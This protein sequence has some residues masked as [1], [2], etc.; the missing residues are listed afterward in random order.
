MTELITSGVRA[1]RDRRRSAKPDT[2]ALTQPNARRLARVLV[3]TIASPTAHEIQHLD[4][5]EPLDDDP[6]DMVPDGWEDEEPDAPTAFDEASPTASG[7]T[8]PPTAVLEFFVRPGPLSDVA[9]EVNAPLPQEHHLGVAGLPLVQAEWLE[10]RRHLEAVGVCIL[11]RQLPAIQSTDPRHA[12]RSLRPMTNA[13]LNES[14]GTR[15]SGWASRNRTAPV[16]CPWGLVR[17][18]FFTWGIGP[19]RVAVYEALLNAVLI[20]GAAGGDTAIARD[21]RDQAIAALE[22]SSDSALRQS[23]LSE[24]ART[25]LP[26]LDSVRKLVSVARSL[27]APQTSAYIAT[28]RR[29]SLFWSDDLIGANA[30]LASSL[31]DRGLQLARFAV[32]GWE[33]GKQWMP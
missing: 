8:A 20:D 22:T 30:M 17:L 4:S 33:G 6:L 12:Y 27:G 9:V 13:D 24:Q 31:S 2:D 26:A 3:S 21:A 15:G 28:L 19:G 7:R 16:A 11:N 25:Q 32:A 29:D 18:E 14:A 1:G 10:R 23:T 5:D